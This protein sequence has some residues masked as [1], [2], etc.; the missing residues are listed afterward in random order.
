MSPKLWHRLKLDM[1]NVLCQ[2]NTPQKCSCFRNFCY[3]WL[4]NELILSFLSPIK[5]AK[6]QSNSKIPW[7]LVKS[8]GRI[9]TIFMIK[10]VGGYACK[11]CPHMYHVHIITIFWHLW[12]TKFL[13]ISNSKTF[14]CRS[15]GGGKKNQKSSFS[16]K[17]LDRFWWE[18]NM[19][20]RSMKRF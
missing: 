8:N 9:T 3:I 4:V 5:G 14:F 20:C 12:V 13:Q 18:R 7:T 2:L 17:W 16:C 1:T 10:G 19:L 15:Y 6:A 11:F